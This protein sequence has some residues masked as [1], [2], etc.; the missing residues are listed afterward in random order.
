[1]QKYWGFIVEIILGFIGG[2]INFHL[3]FIFTNNN[4]DFMIRIFGRKYLEF[5]NYTVCILIYI[6]VFAILLFITR[7]KLF[8]VTYLISAILA[9]IIAHIIIS[10]IGPGF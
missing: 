2:I 1:M 8:S 9:L 7:R 6:V 3:F 10:T 5:W 4:Q